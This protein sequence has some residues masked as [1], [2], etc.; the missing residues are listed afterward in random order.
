MNRDIN[1]WKKCS[2]RSMAMQSLEA[3]TYGF[4]D[5]RHD[6]IELHD[7]NMRLKKLLLVASFPRRGTDEEKMNIDDF[8][9]LVQSFYTKD[10]LENLG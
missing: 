3:V 10:Q 1:R 9:K 8:S 2:P 4:D 6:I 7:Q 5:A